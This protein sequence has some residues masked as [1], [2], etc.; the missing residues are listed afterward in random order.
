VKEFLQWAVFAGFGIGLF[1]WGL[2]WAR[3]EPKLEQES[4][5]ARDIRR[6]LELQLQ[7]LSRSLREHKTTSD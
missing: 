3:R 2:I 7:Q 5:L 4:E 1:L 6:E